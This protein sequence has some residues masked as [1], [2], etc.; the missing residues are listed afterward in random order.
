MTLRQF[1]R[2]AGTSASRMSGYENA[3]LALTTHVLDRLSHVADIHARR[4]QRARRA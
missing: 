1:A 2:P 4:R 3:K